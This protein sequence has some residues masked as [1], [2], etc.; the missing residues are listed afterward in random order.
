MSK[1]LIG[2]VAIVMAVVVAIGFMVVPSSALEASAKGKNQF[3]LDLIVEAPGLGKDG[4]PGLGTA[5]TIELVELS[6]TSGNYN[7]DSFFDV[8]YVSNIGSSGLDG[9]TAKVTA[10]FDSFFDIEYEIG[11]STRKV[12]TFDTEMISMSLTVNLNDP[13]NPQG[14]IDVVRE[15]LEKKGGDVYVGHVT[16]IR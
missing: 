8:Y 15:A 7:V 13:P 3:Q 14:A 16:L 1:R 10:N 2:L 9:N 6:L 5:G 12:G 4:T 11:G